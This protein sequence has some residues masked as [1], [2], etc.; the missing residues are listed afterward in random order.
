M[1]RFLLLMCLAPGLMAQ[2]P[3]RHP[4]YNSLLEDGKT[5]L[6]EKD[7][8]MA[9]RLLE[10]AA[11]GLMSD[12]SAIEEIAVLEVVIYSRLD[13]KDNR[14]KW[15]SQAKRLLGSDNP[16]K[17]ENITPAIWNEYLVAI[18]AK[19]P[20]IP[21]TTGDL[22]SYVKEFPDN[23][24]G[25]AALIDAHLEQNDRSE[26]RDAIAAGLVRHPKNETL[27]E[28]AL[29]FSVTL[30]KGKGADEYAE[31]L[32]SAAPRNSLVHEYLGAESVKRK[33]YDEA[34][35][36]F[37]NVRS[38]ALPGT[39]LYKAQLED[40]LDK[41]QAEAKKEAEKKRRELAANDRSEKA[42]KD[43]EREERQAREA[44]EEAARKATE[45]EARKKARLEEE[46]EASRPKPKVKDE[47][48][49]AEKKAV[50]QTDPANVLKAL[51][52]Q[53]KA[54]PSDDGLKFQLISLY[55]DQDKMPKAKKLLR[56][57]GKTKAASDPLYAENFARFN[58][59]DSKFNT[60]VKTLGALKNL[61]AQ[62]RY[63]LGMSYYKLQ[64]DKNAVRVLKDLDRKAFPDL[65]KVDETIAQR[66]PLVRKMSESSDRLKDL[67]RKKRGDLS[68]DE[69]F[70]LIALYLADDKWRPAERLIKAAYQEQAGNSDSQYYYGRLLLHEKEY[71]AASRIFY[72]LAK[73]SYAKG[74]VFYYG[75][76]AAI[77]NGDKVLADYMFDRAL[78]SGTKFEDEIKDLKKKDRSSSDGRPG[79]LAVSQG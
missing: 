54:K 76:L 43:K 26:A 70:E 11:F 56:K 61:N 32:L 59:Q 16:S 8:P 10:I 46:K 34:L 63:Y 31:D 18:G 15:L 72:S 29:L 5:A 2:E 12:Q 64:D 57:V 66:A 79:E 24:S 35:S 21:K 49:S 28:K 50:A 9:A 71:A 51:E 23:V 30:D 48:K 27:L 36:H 73:G 68:L 7:L 6:G 20:P 38:E 77:R 74:E 52:A 19:A 14:F 67:E 39:A 78:K 45:A 60:V 58:Y 17:P 22:K 40:A 37:S 42:R 33:D 3:T 44:R 4:F 69:Q 75:G 25:W 47:G 41:R 53:V 62:T 65:E 55:M 1:I 13:D